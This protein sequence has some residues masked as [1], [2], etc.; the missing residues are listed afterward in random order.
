[1]GRRRATHGFQPSSRA[2]CSTRRR[3]ARAPRRAARRST[4]PCPAHCSRWPRRSS[5]RCPCRRRPGLTLR[6][7]AGMTRPPI[8]LSSTISNAEAGQQRTQAVRRVAAQG[9]GMEGEVCRGQQRQRQGDRG[10][11][12]LPARTSRRTKTAAT[13]GRKAPSSSANAQA[14]ASR[15]AA[16]PASHSATSAPNAGPRGVRQ[17]R[18][19]LARREQEADDHRHHDAEDH[20]VRVPQ[21]GRQGA[22]HGRTRP[23]NTAGHRRHGRDRGERCHQVEGPEAQPQ[24]GP[25]ARRAARPGAAERPPARRSSSGPWSCL[26]AAALDQRQLV[27]DVAVVRL[28]LAHARRRARAAARRRPGASR[29]ARTRESAC[30]RSRR[31]RSARGSACS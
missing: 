4:G 21:R 6:V 2:P 3:P 22:G 14:G 10:V 15:L 24:A 30:W 7:K 8:R 5:A 29:R 11:A 12:P 31:R 13:T 27:V 16:R 17:A 20:L 26:S 23:M 18:P 19:R 9:R 1:M 25:A 28:V